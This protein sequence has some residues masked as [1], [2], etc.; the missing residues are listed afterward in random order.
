MSS[1]YRKGEVLGWGTVA[2]VYQA[3]DELLNRWVAIKELKQPFA[4]NEVFAR[5][6]R[7]QALKM[8]DVSNRYVMATHA[9]DVDR[10]VQALV[11]ELADQT[12]GQRTFQQTM[13]P[14]AVIR[15]LRQVL[16]GLDVLHGRG[17]VHG[18]VKPE[19]IFVCEGE[20]KIGDF[21]LPV[22]DGA[23]PYPVSRARYASPETL[24]SPDFVGRGSDV[25]SLG[26]VAY[27]LILGPLRLEQVVE[28]LMRDAGHK[29][30]ARSQAS[31][32]DELWPRFHSSVLDLPPIH[33]IEPGVPTALSLTLQKMVAKD[34]GTRFANC[35][36]ALASLGSAMPTELPTGSQRFSFLGGQPVSTPALAPPP[37]PYRAVPNWA[38]I[39]GGALAVAVLLAGGAWMFSGRS[40]EKTVESRATVT[41]AVTP[42]EISLADRL[43]RLRSNE[44]DVTVAL[45]PQIDG[46]RPRLALGTDL[47]FR[48]QSQ[49]GGWL[50]LFA[51][52][53]DGSITCLYPNRQRSEV[54][55]GESGFLVLPSD[56][57]SFQLAAEEPAGL[58][59]I[60]ALVSSQNLPPL[61][62][63]N[64]S[65]T[66]RQYPLGA[67]AWAFADW[68]EKLRKDNSRETRMAARDFE[69]GAAH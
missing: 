22:L 3:W 60:F 7:A 1:I 68:L 56:S 28:E 58:Q 44:G 35:K 19:N 63:G 2:V 46:E 18:A 54:L 45:E 29:A 12:V 36:K 57:D 49:R 17:L 41:P 15:L 33:E 48:V 67:P 61:P 43:L 69:I 30:Q 39:G 64:D 38:G 65:S 53:P 11:R 25:Y 26:I 23:P 51:L 5:A 8:L 62:L 52:S 13:E 6:F 31:E 20:Y 50:L 16:A 55:L 10:N 24:V 37:A 32:R 9:M 21:G 27:E 47:H 34:L 14:D 40:P 42:A 4:G 66:T 59:W